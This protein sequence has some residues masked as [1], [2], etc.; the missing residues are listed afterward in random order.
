M[1]IYHFGQ[2]KEN[3]DFERRARVLLSLTMFYTVLKIEFLFVV[4]V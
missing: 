2:I 4:G 1:I 3:M